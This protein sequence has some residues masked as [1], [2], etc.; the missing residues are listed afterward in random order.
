MRKIKCMMYIYIDVTV[1]KK[2]RTT[3]EE[4]I[5]FDDIVDNSSSASSPTAG[6]GKFIT[7]P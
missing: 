7:F 5:F 4:L 6:K 2:K 3:V 1:P